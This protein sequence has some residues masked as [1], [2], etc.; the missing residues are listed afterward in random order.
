MA[1]EVG[2]PF[3]YRRYVHLHVNGVTELQRAP[4][5]YSEALIF[6]DLQSPGADYLKQWYPNNPDGD[7]FKFEGKSLSFVVDF[8]AFAS[9]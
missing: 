4:L 7:L 6:E 8:H 9:L 2:L 5:L 3:N 1:N